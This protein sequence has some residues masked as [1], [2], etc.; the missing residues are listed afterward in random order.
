LAEVAADRLTLGAVLR[1][2]AERWPD[3]EALL[4][5]DAGLSYG[6]LGAL[7][8]RFARALVA[9]G[10]DPGRHVGVLMNNS[11]EMVAA[12]FG[13][14]RAG[15]VAVP[16]NGRLKGAELAYVLR[17]A[18]LQ[19]LVTA[20]SSFQLVDH[21]GLVAEVLPSLA[22]AVDP[23]RLRLPEAPELRQVVSFG[24]P[25]PGLRPAAE[26]LD[27]GDA[28]DL[29]EVRRR[30][31]SALPSEPAVILYTSGTT[32]APKGCVL[33]NT[34]F[35]TPCA[36]M[37]R[38]RF[39]MRP[40]DRMFDPLPLFH[41]GAITPL[42]GCVVGGAA[43][44]GVRHFR[45]DETVDF[46]ARI[47]PTLA[48][49]VWETIWLQVLDHP[50][51]P[52]VD[53]SRL[54]DI[55]LVGVPERLREYQ[56]SL[57]GTPLTSSYGTS[58][59]AP[60]TFSLPTDPE[61]VRLSTVG[62]PAPGVTLRVVDPETGLDLPAGRA[63]EL[64]YR[65]PMVFQGY[66]RDPEG[67]AAIKDAE[68]WLHSG[69]LGM[70]REDGR[71]VYQGRIKDMLKV[72]GENVA[73]AEVE[74]LLIQHSAVSLAYVVGAP[75]RYYTEVPAAFVELKPGASATEEELIEFC[76]GRIATFKIP[77]YVRFVSEW[78]MSATKVQKVVLRQRL[79]DELE[80]KGITA[81]PRLSAR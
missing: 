77:R 36:E 60:A 48:Y 40:G 16:V 27:E 9:A 56:A 72:G 20:D 34:A 74:N 26:F 68:G 24:A 11:P 18:D 64:V 80:A 12:F 44:C 54:R 70:L 52:E 73:A 6:E 25:R 41:L 58:E 23:S 33:S 5:P 8:L 38:I 14:A 28:V 66:Y 45:A 37:A 63:G 79:K 2:A 78:P 35:L 65:G 61:E 10:V 21:A 49:P 50:R 32:A 3:E 53:L 71:V 39:L 51:F 67:T 15:A 31:D 69:D 29:E 43:F 62:F 75:D 57:P 17:Q 76:K 55:H 59:G 22:G 30:E 42:G 7:S 81:A 1:D 46:L 4:F 47:R 13:A 19:V